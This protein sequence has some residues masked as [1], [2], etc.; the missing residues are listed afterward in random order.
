MQLIMR[1]PEVNK[2]I[3]ISPQPDVYD[4]TFL[5]PCPI[6][7]LVLFGSH[8]TP[9]KVSI[10]SKNF[11]AITSNDLKLIKG[12]MLEDEQVVVMSLVQRVMA[13][14][15]NKLEA[16]QD[17]VQTKGKH[18][19]PIAEQSFKKELLGGVIG[20]AV[21]YA[22]GGMS[23]LVTG[24]VGVALAN[25]A[26]RNFVMKQAVNLTLWIIKDPKTSMMFLMMAKV[27]L[28]SCCKE[29]A[30]VMLQSSYEAET[31]TQSFVG[32]VKNT[33]G[34][35]KDG[36]SMAALSRTVLNGDN[37][38]RMW[39]DGGQYVATGIATAI[40]GPA[41]GLAASGIKAL[42][43]GAIDCA[44]EASQMGI[45]LAAYQSDI[46]KGTRLVAEIMQ[47]VLNPVAVAYSE[48]VRLAACSRSPS[49]LLT[50]IRSASSITPRLMP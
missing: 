38:K 29:M 18:A 14:F 49:A 35:M 15:T 7:G 28:R 9:H 48:T 50:K 8:T 41:G 2:F 19:K 23:L 12:P 42:V 25:D 11:K 24:I 30:R 26:L 44:K 13:Y 47:M 40:A 39:E 37:W 16:W 17:D 32:S 27:F 21:A 43:G 33:L 5:A 46:Q 10:E 31:N 34:N 6:S 22:T 45:E 3:A 36:F 20:V 4:F 1:R